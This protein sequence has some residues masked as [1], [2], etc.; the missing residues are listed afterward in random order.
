MSR[1]QS[2]E[3]PI[4][5]QILAPRESGLQLLKLPELDF[6]ARCL[7]TSGVTAEQARAFRSKLW[8][9]HIDSQYS[10]HSNSEQNDDTESAEPDTNLGH[11]KSS[12]RPSSRDPDSQHNS[13]PF[14]QRIR[15]GMVVRCAPGARMPSSDQVNFV[16]ILCPA[17]AV[18]R[19]VKDFEGK[20]VKQ[21]HEDPAIA[22][23]RSE[24]SG[25]YLC[26]LMSPG[27]M[28]NAYEMRLWTQIV[29]DV[30][31]MEAEVM[32]EYDVASRFYYIA[33]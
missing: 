15:P 20:S 29:I 5:S 22:S 18:G 31:Q 17:D 10:R 12:N 23:E 30:A 13:V 8:Q 24:T 11:L 14:Q 26:A 32:V 2:G 28:A 25:K 3:V 4:S 21:H 19:H 1:E 6:E 27:T 33:V 9:M 7:K 16:I